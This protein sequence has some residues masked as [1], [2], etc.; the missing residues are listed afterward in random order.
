VSG[1]ALPAP[2][3]APL[4]P[5]ACAVR[6]FPCGHPLFAFGDNIFAARLCTRPASGAS[7]SG[8][9]SAIGGAYPEALGRRDPAAG[10]RRLR[11]WDA[12]A[13]QQQAGVA[14]A[15]GAI[16][17]FRGGGGSSGGGPEQLLRRLKGL[18]EHARCYE[19]PA[20]QAAARA[21][22]PFGVVRFYF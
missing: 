19:D 14:R 4:T 18:A 22:V 20:L 6:A 21:L 15:G 2:C 8:G 1:V 7:A 3:G 16:A 5:F 13:A 11:L 17:A 9:G 10:S 12:A